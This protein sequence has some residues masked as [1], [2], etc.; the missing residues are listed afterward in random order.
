MKIGKQ[1][2]SA[3][4]IYVIWSAISAF[5]IL[6]VPIIL[7]LTSSGGEQKPLIWIAYSIEPILWGYLLICIGTTLFFYKWTKEY[8]FVNAATFG[9]TVWI[10]SSYYFT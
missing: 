1:A 4:S 3:G 8:W 2:I 10:L 7:G 5:S 6:V 9:T